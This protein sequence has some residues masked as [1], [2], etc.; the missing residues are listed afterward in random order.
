M[1]IFLR[2]VSLMLLTAL[3]ESAYAIFLEVDSKIIA[4]SF[5]FVLYF[6]KASDMG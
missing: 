6:N 4:S 3:P 2:K 5:T 1:P